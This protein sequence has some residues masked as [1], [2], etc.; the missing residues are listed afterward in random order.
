MRHFAMN[1]EDLIAYLSSLRAAK[2]AQSGT[3]Q[4]YSIPPDGAVKEHTGVVKKGEAI[5]VDKEG[6]PVLLCRCGNPLTR[7]PAQ[8]EAENMLQPFVTNIPI[9]ELRETNVVAESVP[10]DTTFAV[11][12]P[13]VAEVP[14]IVVPPATGTS[15]IP[16]ASGGGGGGFLPLLAALG[17]AALIPS[18]G[19]GHGAVPE[20]MSMIAMATGLTALA[21]RRRNRK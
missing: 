18:G 10:A 9:T 5:F 19:G 17:G 20:P 15:N 21:L 12:P 6:N 14:P 2:L 16:I 11:V 4:I 8:P 7:G 3:Y 13:G 1:E